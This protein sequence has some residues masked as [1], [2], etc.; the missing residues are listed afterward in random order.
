MRARQF[1][2]VNVFFYAIESPNFV[3]VLV[4]NWQEAGDGRRETGDGRLEAQGP[5]PARDLG[6]KSLCETWGCV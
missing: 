6:C 4:G 2:L 3:N 5:P 1:W